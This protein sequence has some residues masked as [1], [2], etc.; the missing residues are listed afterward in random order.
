[1]EGGCITGSD[2]LRLKR[3]LASLLEDETRGKEETE[4]VEAEMSCTL[5]RDKRQVACST[6][7]LT[8]WQ[9]PNLASS[10]QG[11]A[12]EKPFRQP[13]IFAADPFS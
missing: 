5:I 13:L 10:N 11:E 2:G 7:A 3:K 6:D 4:L 9:T 1:M 12:G 8:K